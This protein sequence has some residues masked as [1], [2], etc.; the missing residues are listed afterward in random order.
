MCSIVEKTQIL[1]PNIQN[2]HFGIQTHI[3]GLKRSIYTQ[4]KAQSEIKP[5]NRG[6]RG[7]RRWV[8]RPQNFCCDPSRA[9]YNYLLAKWG[10]V[11]F[12]KNWHI[13]QKFVQFIDEEFNINI[14]SYDYHTLFHSQ[15]CNQQHV[16]WKSLFCYKYIILF[17]NSLL[18]ESV[19]K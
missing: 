3:L 7:F 11:D 1:R 14:F 13:F 10:G 17:F 8:F 12:T 19:S 5:K 15:H 18:F 2:Y 16:F 6:F 9:R 4:L